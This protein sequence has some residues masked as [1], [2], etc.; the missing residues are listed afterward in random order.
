MGESSASCCS[1]NFIQ[2]TPKYRILEDGRLPQGMMGKTA[3]GTTRSADGWVHLMVQS[4]LVHQF[5]SSFFLLPD[6]DPDLR[7]LLVTQRRLNPAESLQILQP[8]VHQLILSLLP[9]PLLA[10]LAS[11]FVL[12]FL[13][14]PET[15]KT[16]RA[17]GAG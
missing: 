12:F 14:A 15:K 8:S 9:P 7:W 4:F 13:I 5:P 3:E 2:L 6:L 17:L 11:V 1:Q 10:R 16:S